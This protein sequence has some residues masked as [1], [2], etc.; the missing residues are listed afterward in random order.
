MHRHYMH[1]VRA[2]V[3]PS[4]LKEALGLANN[5]GQVYMKVNILSP[6][7]SFCFIT[8]HREDATVQMGL[9]SCLGI[10]HHSNDGSSRVVLGQ[11][12]S[13]PASLNDHDNGLTAGLE[14]GLHGAHSFCGV[15]GNRCQMV[16]FLEELQVVGGSLYL[17][18]NQVLHV[19][20]LQ[21]VVP[22][23]VP[24]DSMMQSAPSRTMLAT[25]LPQHGWDAV[26]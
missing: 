4:H 3:S 26:S 8:Q 1:K 24:S 22:F 2:R 11:L 17:K 25:S 15:V 12:V 14:A 13:T 19:N 18:G 7:I 21:R 5:H 9:G 16:E 6:G 20:S 10:V 23:A